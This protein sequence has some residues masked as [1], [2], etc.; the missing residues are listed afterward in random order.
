M[1]GQTW[2]GVWPRDW[3]WSPALQA[4]ALPSEP[5]G[6]PVG[7]NLCFLFSSYVYRLR[8]Y[9]NNFYQKKK[10]LNR[11]GHAVWCVYLASSWR[12]H[13][14][15]ESLMLRRD[16]NN[17]RAWAELVQLSLAGKTTWGCLA[18][19]IQCLLLSNSLSYEKLKL[20]LMVEYGYCLSL[21]SPQWPWNWVGFFRP[22]WAYLCHVL[23]LVL[24]LQ[25]W[26]CIKWI[27]FHI[28][29]RF[30]HFWLLF[31]RSGFAN[32]GIE[33]EKGIQFLL[34][35]PPNPRHINLFW[36]LHSFP[37]CSR[38]LNLTWI[39]LQLLQEMDFGGK[40]EPRGGSQLEMLSVLGTWHSWRQIL[41]WNEVRGATLC[42]DA[43]CWGVGVRDL[44][45]LEVKEFLGKCA[46]E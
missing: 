11:V 22:Y 13:W 12:A 18:E 5:P 20:T 16:I 41:A 36:D 24:A 17:H 39:Y 44:Y 14:P 37:L 32:K 35:T 28:H 26:I 34:L 23:G 38:C 1:D 45:D 43:E 33:R 21:S 10:K 6:K 9:L 19:A 30:L 15:L 4:E 8:I 25:L 3:T 2:L 46:V 7:I 40:S 27:H 31:W 42:Q 29:L